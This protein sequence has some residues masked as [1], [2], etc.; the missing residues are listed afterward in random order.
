MAMRGRSEPDSEKRG[1]TRSHGHSLSPAFK[2][3]VLAG[4]VK[5]VRLHLRAGTDL[6]AADTRGRSPL[7]LAVSRG[8]LDVC[9]LLLE[10]GA[11]PTTKDNAGNDALAI[12]RSRGDAAIAELL[13][14]VRI[15]PPEFQD[16]NN[17]CYQDRAHE[18]AFNARSHPSKQATL[19]KTAE[20]TP[21]VLE[22]PGK[23]RHADVRVS[24]GGTVSKP[25]ADDNGVFDLSGWQEE[26]ESEA[27][28]DDLSSAIEAATLQE[29]LSRHSPI[30]TDE[31]WYDVEIDLPELEHLGRLH[32][33]IGTK[34]TTAV[35]VLVVDALRNGHVDQE[36]VGRVLAE[37]DDLDD[38]KR[39]EFEANLHVVLGDLGIVIN[40]E[41]GATHTIAEITDEDEDDF[42]D[43][44]TEAIA[45]LGTLWSADADPIVP[46]AKSVPNEFLTRDDEAVLGREIEEGTR[47]VLDT[48]AGSPM[49]V[50]R[51]LS[52]ARNVIDGNIEARELLDAAKAQA[53]NDESLSEDAIA[54]HGSERPVGVPPNS[55]TSLLHLRTIVEICQRSHVDR[56]ALTSRLFDAGLSAEYRAELQRVAE[57]DCACEDAATRIR[58]GLAKVERAKQRFVES[59]LKLVIWVAR[60]YRALPLADRIQ[61]GNIG[62]MKAVDKFEY[63]RGYRFST[64]ATWWIRQT[65]SRAIADFDRIIRLPVHMT[66]TLRKVERA[67]ALAYARDGREFDVDL[68]AALAE[69][70]A[71]RVRKVLA[72][73][74]DPLSMEDPEILD[75]VLAIADEWTPSSEE[76][77]MDAQTQKVVREQVDWLTSRE[78]AVIRRRFGIDCEE[79]TLEEVG[80][81]FGVTRERI[82]Q[83]ESKALRK[84]RHPSR[85]GRLRNPAT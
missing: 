56:A 46:Y 12:A 79:H 3:A 70:P 59:N 52:D 21:H 57:E 65:I 24:E 47:E 8:H 11:D 30:D 81:E 9:K 67:Q 2:M 64:Y 28:P 1:P 72:V 5:S 38:T 36:R 39:A 19:E 17:E 73:P 85:A 35:R 71:D 44:A 69:L 34:T 63:R 14:R 31:N 43:L 77:V 40:D 4:A 60:K 62:L 49:V 45:F 18:V 82:R 33:R 58:T 26:V 66:E 13:N 10:A 61:V 84:L 27:P 37:D 22:D 51:L 20:V 74:G 16:D 32:S 80:K 6:D 50:T 48:I 54:G 15:S 29:T 53:G 7:L 68:I 42:G 55:D 25:P 23:R 78:A 41:P 75:E 76:V 83:I